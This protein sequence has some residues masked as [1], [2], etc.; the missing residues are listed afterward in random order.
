MSEQI[1]TFRLDAM[2]K[3]LNE[4][5]QES[6]EFHKTF[7]EKFDEMESRYAGKWVERILI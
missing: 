6:K 7:L 1:T 3:K 4:I 5:Q 2:E